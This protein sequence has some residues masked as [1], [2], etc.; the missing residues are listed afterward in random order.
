MRILITGTT[1]FVGHELTASY[2][3]AIAA[4]SLR[5]ATPDMV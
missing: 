1:G 2:T 5:N 4:P 3:D